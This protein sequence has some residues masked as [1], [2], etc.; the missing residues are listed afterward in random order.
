MGWFNRRVE[1]REQGEADGQTWASV[2]DVPADLQMLGTGTDGGMLYPRRY[3]HGPADSAKTGAAEMAASWWSRAL[4]SASV[5]GDPTG[6][7]TRSMLAQVGRALIREGEWVGLIVVRRGRPTLVP[8]AA[9]WIEGDDDPAAW[10]YRLTLNGP[11]TSRIVRA[12]ACQ[13]A[14][15]KWSAIPS[16]PWRG[17]GPLVLASQTAR[18]AFMTEA[19]LA[20]QAAIPPGSKTIFS[21]ASKLGDT[22]RDRFLDMLAES[23]FGI[24]RTPLVLEQGGTVGT[25]ETGIAPDEADISNAKDV[26]A[27]MASACGIPTALVA[28]GEG[29]AAAIRE[30]FRTFLFGSV[31]PVAEVLAEELRLK[32]DAPDLA[33]SFEELRAADV[34]GRARAFGSLVKAGYPPAMAAEACGLPVAPESAEGTDT[35]EAAPGPQDGPAGPA[36]GESG[37]DGG[38]QPQGRE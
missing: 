34:Q 21:F 31:M 2:A 7:V 23:E 33:L 38:M 26:L 1:E 28:G 35:G 32:L 14:H 10:S 36:S 27:T 20:D 15:L 3:Y 9:Q 29:S 37:T 16:R 4:A 11:S 12:P 5:T 6:A 25:L 13:V 24:D 8:A 19:R 22:Q 18:R 30:N 17:V